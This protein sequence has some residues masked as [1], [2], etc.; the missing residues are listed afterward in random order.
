MFDV[1]DH[2]DELRSHSIEWLEACRRSVVIEVRSLQ[3]EELA[4][5][6]V[7]DERGR[8]D[9]SIGLD[10]ESARTVNEKVE[11]RERW[12]RCPPSPQLRAPGT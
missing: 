3:S 9:V 11:P 10:G 5:V 7:L 2:L 6:R 12:S 1:A 8:I 4:I